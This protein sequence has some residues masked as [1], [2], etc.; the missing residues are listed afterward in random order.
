MAHQQ[1]VE[2]FQKVKL[3]YP[4]WFKDKVILD[5]GSLD[6]NGSNEYLFENCIYVGVDLGL[7]TNVDII[8]K[9]HE[10]KFPDNSIDV[11]ISS[12]C[13]E[14]DIYYCHSLKNIY[15]ILKPGG[16]F[17]FS[18]AT[19]GR[20]EHGTKRSSP[21]DAVLLQNYENWSDYYKNL[22]EKDIT[23]VF[24]L[25]TDF[26]TYKFEVNKQSNDLYFYG[27]KVG[28]YCKDSS[29][30]SFD[31]LYE[32]CIGKQMQSTFVKNLNHQLDSHN[33]KLDLNIQG[34]HKVVDNH[35]KTT[36]NHIKIILDLRASNNKLLADKEI[37]DTEINNLKQHI[38]NVTESNSRLQDKINAIST[39]LNGSLKL[40]LQ[41]NVEKYINAVNERN[42]FYFI[43]HYLKPSNSYNLVRQYL[44]I[45]KSGLFDY[46]HY[47]GSFLYDKRI[48]ILLKN[49]FIALLHYI[50]IGEYENRSPNRHFNSNYYR[51]N[52]SDVIAPIMNLLYHYT[53]YGE[54]EN[55]SPF[56][57]FIPNN[58]QEANPDTV[59][60]GVSPLYH[61]LIFGYKENRSLEKIHE[62]SVELKIEEENINSVEIH[63][64]SIKLESEN[65]LELINNDKENNI[66][67]KNI[68][69]DNSDQNK[70]LT[71][72]NKINSLKTGKLK[73][74]FSEI[75]LLKI[76]D[77]ELEDSFSNLAFKEVSTPTVSIIIPYYK[78]MTFLAE[79]LLSIHN[80][81]NFDSYEII[82]IDD[83]GELELSEFIEK[84]KHIKYVK[85]DTNLGFIRS[86]NRGVKYALGK[87][88][89]F[90]NSDIQVGKNWLTKLVDI[91][92]LEENI[93]IV[94]AK[95][96]FPNG[97]LQEAGCKI[98]ED[99]SSHMIGLWDDPKLP[100]YNYIKEVEYTS[101]AC[102][103]IKSELFNSVGGFDKK[104]IPSYY[105]DADLCFKIRKKGYRVIYQ[106]DSVIYHHLSISSKD[107]SKDYK[108]SLILINQ[109]KFVE[110]WKDDIFQLNKARLI[111]FFLPQFHPFDEND[112]FWSKGFTEWTNV[113]NAKPQFKGHYQPRLPGELGFY[114]LRVKDTLK[115]QIKLAKKYGVYGFC[116]HYYLFGKKKVMRSIL[117]SFFNDA[118]LDFPFCINWANESW[119]RKW[120]GDDSN[121]I[122][123]QNHS[124]ESDLFFIEDIKNILQDKRYIKVFGKPLILIYRPLLFPNISETIASWRKYCKNNSIGDIYVA[125]I[126]TCFED[127]AEYINLGLNAVVEFPPHNTAPIKDNEIITGDFEG[128][129]FD[130][131][132]ALMNSI[133]KQRPNYPFH[134]SVMP[135]WDNTARRGNQSNIFINSSPYKYRAWLESN[136]L[137]TKQNNF[138]DEQLIFI[139]AW[140]EWAEGAV[141]EPDLK[142]GHSY[143][144]ATKDALDVAKLSWSK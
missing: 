21:D 77:S 16:F 29:S 131:E 118:D 132:N 84:I 43:K 109:Q 91:Y 15:R 41:Y 73:T 33:K 63:E 88:Y 83:S 101:G 17:L 67:I 141:L 94:G 87:Y 86:C 128:K 127:Q 102:L 69:D 98:K 65:G 139:N 92:N 25:D 44:V 116:F 74:A 66:S 114:D 124:S 4:D 60:A 35:V 106:P 110:R 134:K 90:L 100:Q 117:D 42:Y 32:I 96:L 7:G 125:G 8:S 120:D 18:C 138:S 95:I 136:I 58:Y 79:T 5:I 61:Y 93:G 54:A 36:N 34:L 57:G 55:R 9:A 144:Q 45:L 70:Y 89:L 19:I 123:K 133:A 10:L 142:H 81:T 40:K 105:E 23:E 24:N 14:H 48:K 107:I 82:I 68:T 80:N 2:Y 115:K 72:K 49:K 20:A 22:E 13:F 104:Y 85:N 76:N 108:K 46:K 47:S 1:Q 39:S 78:F 140:N 38:N 11:I 113:V 71:I 130:Y 50:L 31:C 12:E 26:S 135:S 75:E 97:L 59:E 111:A 51:T 62:Q 137:E 129:I 6:I 126:S 56:Q 3:L 53:K 143:L 30:I 112:L 99:G 52:N 121:T 122:I 37:S 103:L 119:T 28:D 27:F 64:Q